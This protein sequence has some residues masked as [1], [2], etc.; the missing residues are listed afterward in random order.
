MVLMETDFPEPVAPATSRWG[1]RARSVTTGAPAMS[2]PRAMGSFI[3]P[4]W[5]SSVANIS[6]RKT[7]SRSRFGISIPTTPLPGMGATMRIESAWS[8]M[9]RSSARLAMRLT[10][11]PGPG[12]YSNMVMT[13]P[14]HISTTSP[15]TLK[16]SSFFSSSRAFM[17]RRSRSTLRRVWGGASRSDRGGVR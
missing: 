2:L 3:L 15:S 13:G 16:S 14:G 4:R 5:N 6:L 12:A 1:M 9:E 17:V 10:L 8:A 11:M 7:I